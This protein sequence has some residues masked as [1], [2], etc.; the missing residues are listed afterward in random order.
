MI[1]KSTTYNLIKSKI[2]ITTKNGPPAEFCR[3]PDKKK[4]A[5][6][7][8]Q[9]SN[10]SLIVMNDSGANYQYWLQPRVHN[11]NKFLS[12]WRH[13]SWSMLHNKCPDQ[14]QRSHT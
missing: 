5:N 8:L 6:Q 13:H 11:D 1:D 4:P 7:C 10:S 3:Q 9:A 12:Y 14:I 2:I